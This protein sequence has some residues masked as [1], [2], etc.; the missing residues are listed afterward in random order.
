[1]EKS[2]S[3]LNSIL[4]NKSVTII[5]VLILVVVV[6]SLINPNYVSID[7]IR[8]ILFNC[9]LSGT[10]SVGVGCLLIS[11]NNDL[12]CG[13]VGCMGGLIISLLMQTGMGWVP[14]LLLTILF[15]CLA[16][17]INA[18]L[19]TVCK[20]MPFIATLA[21]MSV[22]QGLGYIISNNLTIMLNNEKFWAICTGD[23]FGV[24]PYAFLYACILMAIYG[25]ILSSTKFGRKIYMVGGN[26]QAARLA[27]I[28]SNKITTILMI[29]CSALAAFGGS[30][31]AGRMHGG[32]PASV[33]GT[34]LTSITAVVMGGVAFGG[35]S[36]SMLGAFFGVLLLNAFNNALTVVGLGAYWSMLASGLLLVFALMLDYGNTRRM[37]K[38]MKA[39]A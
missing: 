14:A 6:A 29:N 2:T 9:A 11:G 8:T 18:T 17:G 10:I 38:S 4:R 22:W 12:S 39:N 20:M 19:A 28:N 35:G 33:H 34:Q 16:G 21:M 5:L 13:A 36:G 1:M 26:R 31:L 25:F 30:I 24:I 7:N 3:P 37:E 27:G 23:I 15:G 32:N